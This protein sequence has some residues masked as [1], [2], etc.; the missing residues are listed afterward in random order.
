MHTGIYC[1]PRQHAA[2]VHFGIAGA[3]VR[4]RAVRVRASVEVVSIV[5]YPGERQTRATTVPLVWLLHWEVFGCVARGAGRRT[6]PHQRR[7][8]RRRARGLLR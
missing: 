6:R 8:S 5:G 4:G 2:D 3:A 1:R 7:W